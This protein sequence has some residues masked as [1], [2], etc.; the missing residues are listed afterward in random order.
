MAQDSTN[1]Y[2]GEQRSRT[3]LRRALRTAMIAMTFP[4][5]CV[6]ILRYRLWSLASLSDQTSSDVLVACLTAVACF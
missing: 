2:P 5:L 1:N 6:D 3:L 4:N